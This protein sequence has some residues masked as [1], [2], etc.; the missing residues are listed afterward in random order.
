MG[1]DEITTL[2]GLSIALKYPQM[3]EQCR[4]CRSVSFARVT[5]AI[6]TY[7]PAS[8]ISDLKTSGFCVRSDLSRSK[9]SVGS[10]TAASG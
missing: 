2:F 7:F 10:F 8:L 9:T 3:I 4:V 5:D 6:L 1:A